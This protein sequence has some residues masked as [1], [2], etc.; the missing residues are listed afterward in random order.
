M[1]IAVTIVLITTLRLYDHVAVL[2]GG[3][4]GFRTETAVFYLLRMGFTNNR[5][6]YASAIAFVLLLIIGSVSVIL[7]GLMR[8]RE[9]PAV[10]RTRETTL[11]PRARFVLAGISV[12]AFSLPLYI[13][14]VNVLKINTQISRQPLALPNPVSMQNLI[15]GLTRSDNLL[16]IGLRNS[17]IISTATVIIIVPI[18][19]TVAYWVVRRRSRITKIALLVLMSG[20]MIPPHVVFI[21]AV[22]VLEFLGIARTFPGWCCSTSGEASCHSP[23]SSTSALCRH[24]PR[25]SMRLL[26]STALLR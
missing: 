7:V 14:V 17:V 25:V 15:D 26:S 1:T 2:T 11:P 10:S 22:D 4:P 23:C 12:A 8:R 3:G 5:T 16:W 20:M 19:A 9:V 13:A 6:G 18:A 24:S 21:P